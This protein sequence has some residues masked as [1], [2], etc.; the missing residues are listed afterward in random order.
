MLGDASTTPGIGVD[1]VNGTEGKSMSI[2]CTTEDT[3]VS[4]PLSST[5]TAVDAWWI[6]SVRNSLIPFGNSFQ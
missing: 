4:W 5:M 2:V 6:A 3:H 1:V